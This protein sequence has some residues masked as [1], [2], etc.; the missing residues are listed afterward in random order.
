MAT[1]SPVEI[2]TQ[3]TADEDACDAK[4]SELLIPDLVANLRSF[5][6]T[7]ETRSYEWRARQIT[8]LLKML[9]ECEKQIIEAL[10]ADLMA[11][12]SAKIAEI[13]NSLMEITSI[14]KNFKSWMKQRK[15]S[16]NLPVQPASGYLLPEPLGVVL[17]IAPWNY[18]LGLLLM[19][20]AAALAA[21]N[22]CIV[23]P[24]EVSVNVS[25]V[26]ATLLP[27]YLDTRGIAVVEG[28]VP[29]TT[30]VLKEKFDHI[31]YTGN[32]FVGKIVLRAAAEHLTPVT[33][34]LGGKS[35]T[36]VDKSCDLPVTAR[37]ILWAKFL[38]CGQ[39]CVA[40]DYVFVHRDIESKFVEAL[41]AGITEFFSDDVHACSDYG[42][43]INVRH[44]QRLAQMLKTCG[45]SI[46]TGGDVRE[47][48]RFIAP[49][50]VLHPDV[51]SEMMRDEIFGPV[52]PILPYNSIDEVIKFVNAREKPLALYMFGS[53]TQVRQRLL[54]E[55][56]SG[57]V[58][59]NDSAV[60]NISGLPFGGVGGS[61]MGSYR[62]Q[63]G[64]DT[65]SHLKPV[66]D[67]ST[68]FDVKWRYPPHTPENLKW[69]SR[70]M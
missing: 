6:E 25:K 17:I 10:E 66:L 13:N 46:V 34:E 52:L 11:A 33:L 41:T 43:I 67:K 45:G 8:G 31:F 4:A 42:R 47:A 30:A 51:N 70:L 19:P 12:T 36:V 15:V 53:D 28:G 61:G 20:L 59:F 65:F 7:G 48:E 37:R 58:V 64:F 40:P 29:E 49:T 18:P 57:A 24:S 68:W 50:I 26:L 63:H 38:N 3:A 21:G 22:C 5:F 62:G 32:G 44:T 9:N 56:S 2:K 35:P 55:T 54:N 23:K 1:E 14:S 27:K 39:T 69:L 60:H 16:T